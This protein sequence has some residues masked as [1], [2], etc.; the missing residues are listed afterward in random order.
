MTVSAT[1]IE[2]VLAD[3]FG[4]STFRPGQRE[5]ITATLAGRDVLGVLPTAGGKSLCYQLPA[6]IEGGVTLVISP[7]VALMHDQ[8][9]ALARRNITAT[10]ITAALSGEEIAYRLRQLQQGQIRLL[11]IAPERLEHSTFL[12]SLRRLPLRRIV[13][14]EAHCISQ[15]GHDFRP[16]YLRLGMLRSVLG[17]LPILA[18]TATA[19]PTV[20]HD[21]IVQ[22]RLHEPFI[23]IGDF[24]RPNLEFWVEECPASRGYEQKAARV[25]DRIERIKEGAVLVYA[26]TRSATETVAA[27]LQSFGI[28]A[29]SYHAGM[30]DTKRETIQ[31]WF[32]TEQR[33]VLV[34]T[35]AF[36]MGID[37]PNVRAVIHCDLPLSMESYYQEA[38][39]AGRDGRSA[40]CVLLYSSGDQRLQQRLVATQFPSRTLVEETY[41]LIADMLGVSAGAWSDA[42]LRCNETV[43][44]RRLKCSARQIE[45]VLDFLERQQL[46]IRADS[47]NTLCARIITSP[48]RWREYCVTA[49]PERAEAME[50]L[51]RTIAFSR[52]EVELNLRHLEQQ[53]A[54][55]A[56]ALLRAIRAA[57]YARVLEVL[58][59]S[60]GKGIRLVGPRLKRHQLPIEWTVVEQ[61]RQN[62]FARAQQVWEYVQT[63]TCKRTFLLE[64][65][66]QARKEQCGKCT[67]CQ[68]GIVMPRVSRQPRRSAYELHIRRVILS[69]IGQ[70]DGLLRLPSV[71]G[72]VRGRAD[73]ALKAIGAEQSSCFGVLAAVSSA[74][75]RTLLQQLMTERKLWV[76]RPLET[77]TLSA[78]GWEELGVPPPSLQQ[79]AH[80]VAPESI[81]DRSVQTTVEYARKGLSP[82][83]IAEQRRLSLATVVNHLV[84]AIAAGV[85]LPRT[86]LVDRAIYAETLRY[87]QHKP[88]ALLRD[89][90]AYFGGTVEYPLLRL[91][92]A[93]A[94]L[95]IR[96]TSL[97]AE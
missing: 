23:Y 15:W 63:P 97:D 12:D 19:T 21:I 50:V 13:V 42:T 45:S 31:E 89:L 59:L 64:Y 46:I 83:H 86:Q 84:Q 73:A 81:L 82:A 7:L 93:F 68:R 6:V 38:G 44:A 51:L 16:A 57:E 40:Q 58:P 34:A 80:H 22:L 2:Q 87:L 90:H 53:H 66:G 18:L 26:A 20:Q 41:T 67:S 32:V 85:E 35:V 95:E 65:F 29:R 61:R 49:S 69:A 39:R 24:D 79:K 71:I 94:R 36:G 91:T 1:G 25:A 75:I 55:S 96:R 43:L 92:L 9:S 17:N 88:R 28:N 70:F 4:F 56:D 30:H 60:D 8:V 48:E 54:V 11:F 62:A 74:V 76:R 5:I 47:R 10:A 3:Y 72:L 37:K 33:P 77:L 52:Q 14:D 78:S 27:H